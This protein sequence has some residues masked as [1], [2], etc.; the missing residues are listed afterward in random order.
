M[1][2]LAICQALMQQVDTI[3][4]ERHA[5]KVLSITLGIGPLAGV[6]AE[7]LRH[8]FPIASADSVAAGAQL[9]IEASP[10]IVHCDQCQRDSEASSNKLV[11]RHCNNWQTTLVS[12]DELMLNSLEL[13]TDEQTQ[14]TNSKGTTPCAT[15]AAAM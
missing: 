1:H 7:L 15:P 14:Q 5:H 11:C 4:R 8:A 10:I 3:A 12:G 9:I 13:E 6:E 2:E